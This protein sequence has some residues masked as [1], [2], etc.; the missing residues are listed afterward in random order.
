MADA[1]HWRELSFNGRSAVVTGAARGIGRAAAYRL[2]G[3]GARTVIWDRDG[4]MA[5][6]TAIELRA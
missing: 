1:D 2:A 3:L 5:E 4:D 6:R